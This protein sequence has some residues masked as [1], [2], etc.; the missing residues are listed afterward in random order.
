MR[1]AHVSDC[2]LPRLGG[3]EMQVNDLTRRQVAAGH[4]PEV[5]TATP[6]GPA[7]AAGADPRVPIH[8]SGLPIPAEIAN[9]PF[10]S[11]PIRK[12][13]RAGNFDAVHVH[14]GVGSP[15]AAAGLRVALDLGLP[16]VV[17]VHCLR[18]PFRLPLILTPW[19]DRE[20]A[21][22]FALTAVSEAAAAPLRD[23]TG[24]PVTVL[25]NGLDPAQWRVATVDGAIAAP[26]PGGAVGTTQVH[27]VATMRLSVRK[28][29]LPLLKIVAAAR[30]RLAA[31]R[32][33]VDLRLTVFGDG[34]LRP[35][36]ERFVRRAGLGGAVRLAGRID[37]ASL[38]TEY[39]AADLFLAP[40]FL[41][42]FGI[43]ALE[44][45]CAGLP[46][47]AMSD[48]GVTE[49]VADGREGLIADGDDG[50]VE[51]VVRLAGDHALRRS[52][53]EHNRRTEPP[54]AWAT[55]LTRLD[56]EYA[57]AARLTGRPAGSGRSLS[58]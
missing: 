3:I 5:I 4:H 6:A 8:R 42:S 28:R 26:V 37:R 11:R 30:D 25:P 50:M 45:R 53:Q 13:L 47:V 29:P 23:R 38:L 27:A 22:R 2:F 12:V 34:K 36:M 24:V 41:E 19:L 18:P 40:A 17:T 33:G 43:A 16:T 10:P 31:E 35:R 32:S 49:F 58:H 15:F 9:N 51:A 1:I 57:R 7:G 52:I 55:V 44:A 56:G 21:P 20:L 48:T 39:A 54:T 46:V 14:A